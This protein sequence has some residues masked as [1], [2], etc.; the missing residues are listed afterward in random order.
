MPVI[1]HHLQYPY[2]NLEK[3][4]VRSHRF[5]LTLN[6]DTLTTACPST[7]NYNNCSWFYDGQQKLEKTTQAYAGFGQAKEDSVVGSPWF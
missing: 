4:K 7:G 3:F 6:N 1:Y 2:K 5:T